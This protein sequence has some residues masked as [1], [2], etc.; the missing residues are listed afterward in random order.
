[1][2]E[3]K[4]ELKSLLMKEE[5]E[6]VGLKLN[7]QKA[8]IMASGPITSWQI[9]GETME[10]ETDFILGIIADGDCSHEIK[11]CS[12]LGRKVMTN[13]DS[14][15]KS[16]DITL[17]TK[18]CLVKAMVFPVV[19]YRCENWAIKKAERCRIDAF[20]LWCQRRLWRVPWTARRSNQ[21]IL[22]ISP[23]CSLEGLMLK[24][25]L[26]YFGHLV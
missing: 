2:P 26:Q 5:S 3:S 11:R 18:V 14:I 12:L 15:F 8:K 13:L 21:S 19:M 1:M 22:K 7:I 20:E 24:L 17:S 9:D 25:K 23:E 4:E 6:K 16:K 10:T